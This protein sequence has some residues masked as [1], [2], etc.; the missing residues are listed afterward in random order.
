LHLGFGWRTA[1]ARG[2]PTRLPPLV[3]A[4]WKVDLDSLATQARQVLVDSPGAPLISGR[5]VDLNAAIDWQLNGR[6][7][8]VLRLGAMLHGDVSGTVA[9]QP[10]AFGGV[11]GDDLS[12]TDGRTW[13]PFTTWNATLSW[14]FAWRNMDLRVG[15]GYSTVP[16]VWALQA[17][18]I[19]WR[20]GGP[21][22]RAEARAA[23]DSRRAP[24]VAASA[25]AP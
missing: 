5:I 23:R 25:P 1:T 24:Q 8:L 2:I 16:M 21:T 14:Q 10:D 17:N 20:F 4:F 11:F 6:D 15:A 9:F 13:G 18:D 7:S 19:A 22:R 12:L 3:A